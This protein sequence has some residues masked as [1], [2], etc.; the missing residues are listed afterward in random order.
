M[1]QTEMED[2]ESGVIVK[3]VKEAGAEGLVVRGG[4]KEGIFVKEV[5][6][7]SPAS[8]QLGVKEGDQILSATVYFDDVSYED[9]LQIL[10]HAQACKMELC[11][12]RKTPSTQS[13]LER[14]TD[15]HLEMISGEEGAS[16]VERGRRKTQRRHEARISWPKFPSFSR[17]RKAYFKRSHSTS[18]AEEEKLQMSPTTSDTESP[19]K[20]QEDAK[21]KT[22]RQKVK[23]SKGKMSLRSKSADQNENLAVEAALGF[24][25]K[26]E[27]LEETSD[28]QS[29]EPQERML[30]E[31]PQT[32]LLDEPGRKETARIRNECTFPSV[33][34]TEAEIGQHKSELI[35]LDKTLKTTD[36]TKS[37]ADQKHQ[38]AKHSPDGKK[39]KKKERSELKVNIQGKEKEEWSPDCLLTSLQPLVAHSSPKVSKTPD[40]ED[41]A[42]DLSIVLDS[43][44]SP[45]VISHAEVK[46]HQ[47]AIDITTQRINISQS[48]LVD[49]KSA[50]EKLSSQ[51]MAK[52]EN[53]D[54]N[55]TKADISFGMPDV[56]TSQK[57]QKTASG[58]QRK[59]RSILI[60][61]LERYGIR[62]RSSTTDRDLTKTHFVV[63]TTKVDT[64]PLKTIVPSSGGLFQNISDMNSSKSSS[65]ASFLSEKPQE[66]VSD[67]KGS[68]YSKALDVG[69]K[70]SS[71][72]I[73][74]SDLSAETNTDDFKGKFD[75]SIS[76]KF[77]VP[78]MDL[79]DFSVHEPIAKT[80]TDITHVERKEPKVKIKVPNTDQQ[81]LAEK[82]EKKIHLPKREDI[83][84]PGMEAT[85]SKGILPL[86]ALKMTVD[87]HMQKAGVDDVKG[88]SPKTDLSTVK[89]PKIDLPDLDTHQHI[90]KKDITA[91]KV[92]LKDAADI[93]KPKT[94]EMITKQQD[95]SA[96]TPQTVPNTAS[97]YDMGD[98]TEGK[99]KAFEMPK[100]TE[101][102][103]IAELTKRSA[104]TFKLPKPKFPDADSHEPI[105]MTKLES[106][107]VNAEI[108]GPKGEV[109]IQ[110]E[111]E[112]EKI[113]IEQ[114]KVNRPE[115]RMKLPN[116][117]DFEIPGREAKIASTDSIGSLAI[118][119][120]QTGEVIVPAT[121]NTEMQK[122]Q[123]DISANAI[124]DTDFKISVSAMKLPKVE[125]SG[126]DR[127]QQI[128]KT[129]VN[130]GKKADLKN[131]I[132]NT[133][134]Q[135]KELVAQVK[136]GKFKV[137]Q[138][139]YDDISIP[140]LKS[141]IKVQ[142]PGNEV[143]PDITTTKSVEAKTPEA[144]A[145]QT[146]S[147]AQDVTVKMERTDLKY[148]V[149]ESSFVISKPELKLP[150]VSDTE[151]KISDVSDNAEPSKHQM[152]ISRKTV[153][154]KKD[155]AES[156]GLKKDMDSE[157]KGD[158]FE[159]LSKV[160]TEMQEVGAKPDVKGPKL[161][162]DF[163]LPSVN[164]SL[165]KPDAGI[166]VPTVSVDGSSADVEL[167]GTQFK[168]S[169]QT[170]SLDIQGSSVDI[171]GPGVDVDMQGKGA[172]LQGQ[173][174]KFKMAKFGI[175]MPKVKGPEVD[176]SISK[177]GVDISLPK[178]QATAQLPSV[179]VEVPSAE[180]QAELPE[181]DIKDIDVKLKKPKVSFPKFGFSKDGKAPEVDVS[182]SKGEV[183]V[184]EG[185][186]EIKSPEIDGKADAEVGGSP[187]KFKLPHFKLPKFGAS[188][189]K[190]KA[191]LTDVQVDVKVPEIEAP[192]GKVG[193]EV[194]APGID[195]DRPDVELDKTTAEVTMPEINISLPKITRPEI[196]FKTPKA[197]M[198]VAVS[199]PAAE[200]KG[201]SIEGK[202][203]IP[204][205]EAGGKAKFHMPS[206]KMPSL[207]F[208]KPDVKGPKLS[209]DFSLPSVNVS[210]TKPDAGIAVPTVSVDGSS[211]DV[212][213]PGTQFKVSGQ[214]PSLDIQGSSVDIEGPG[215]DVDMQGKGADLQG[216]GSKFK[217]AKFGISMPK[218]KGPEVDISIS[219]PGVDISLPKAQAT[220]QLPSVD[221]EVPSAE[222]QAELPEADIKDIDVKLKKPKVSFP[223][224]G[225]SKDGKAPE[226]D[227]SLSK[228]E[229]PVPEGSVEI[230]SPEI[231]GKADAEVGGSP[232]KFKL[233]HFKLPK[234]GASAP[235]GKA[236]LTDV[237]VDVKV[238]EIEAP[239]GKVGMEVKAP[240]ID[241][242]RPDVELDK[243]TA[244]VTMPEINISLPKI[245][246]P[247]IEFKTPKAEM[248][249]AVSKPAAEMKGPSI[250][251]KTE[252]P[253]IEAGG[254]AKFHMPSI[255]MPSLGFS[256]PDV[257]GPKLSGDFSLPSVNVSL[258]KPDAGIAVPTV[259]VDGSSA[260]VEL[261][262]TQFKVSGQTPSLD[263]QGSSVDIEGPG[264]DVDMQGKGADLQG[265]GSKFKMAK[266]G[267]SMPK[268]KGPEVDISISKPGVDISLPKAQATA[269]LPSVDV[270]VPSAEGQAE[271][272]E[273]DIKDIDV[274]LKKP[275]VSFP[276][277][278]FSKDGKAPEVDVSL[279]KGEVPVPEGSVEIK[280]PEIDGKADAE[281]GGSPSKFKLP[282]FKLPKFGASAPK[283][284]AEL[285]DVQVDVKV[286][287]IEAPSGKV[288]MEVKAPGIDIDR[289]D[290]ELDKTTAEV[291]M[292]EIN[293]SLPKIT[294]P[295]IEFKTPKAEMDVAVSKPAAEMKG[296]SI[297][298]KTE[299]PDI[300]AGG[301]AKFHMPSIKMPSLGFSKPD[302]K[303]PK[304]SGDFS[305]PSV[306]VSLTKPDAGIAVPTVSVD[307]SSADVELPGTQ[308]KVSGQTPS[309]DIQGSSVDIEGP[310]V[311]VDMQ[312][313]G[314]DLQGQGSKF[315]MAK[316]GISMPKVKGPEVDISISKPGVDISLP[317]A[318]ATA[319]LPSVDVE[320]PSAEGQAELP[321]A[322]I[323]DID[324]KLKKPKVSFPKFGFSK[325]GKAPEV[326]VSLSKGEVPVPEGSVEIKSP[327]I[328]GKADAEVGGSPSKFKLPHFKLP[329]FG[330]SAPKGKAELTDVQ[331]DVKVPEIEAP[332]GK[333]GME[334]KAPGIDIDRPD[335]E[336]D[337][338]TAEVTMPEINISLPKITRPE[339]E[340]KTPKAEMDVAVSKP[341]AEM[342]G[343]SI[344]GKTEIP[345]IEAGGKAKFHM[346][347][348]KM[349]SLG[350]SKPDV[351]GPKLS[352]DFSLPSVNVS[353]TKP[354]AGIAVPTVS[355]DGSSA[356]V[357]LPGTQFKVSGQTPSL[358]IQGSSV[359]IEGPGV[360][361]DMQ[362]KGADLQGQ[363]SKFKMAKFGISMPKVKGPEVDISISKPGVDIS[364]PKAQATAQLPSV[365]VE[366]PSAE[367][368]A[369]LPEADIKDID[370]KLKKPKV[371][372]PKFGFSKDGKAPEVDV[373]LSKGEVP[374]PEGSV[375]IKSPEIDGKADAEVGGSPSKFKLPH[376]KLPK[377]GASAPKGKAELTDV[378]V[379]VKVPEIEAPSGKVGMEVKAP[380]IDIDRP[381]VELDKTTAEVTMPEIN[382]SLPKI[383]RP[384][385]EFKTPKAEMD[386]AV[387]K[388]A[389]EMKGP[390]IEGKTEIPDI[391]AGGKAKFHMP[392]IKMPSLGF[393]KPDVKGP[394]LSGDFSL[395]SVNVSLTKPDAGIAVPTVSVD[396]SS[397]DVELP[398]TQF[399]VSGQTP[400]LD[401]QG[402][403]VDIEGPGVDVD[404]QGKGADLQG[405]GSKFKM[406]KF[407]ISMPKVKGPEVDISIS[408]PGVDISLPKAQATAQLPSVDVEVPSA[409]G[410]AELPEADIKDIDVKL[411]KPKVSFPKFG[412]SKDGKAPEV[413]VSLSK[414]EVPVPEGSVEI[415]SPEIDGKAD[416][417]VGGSPSKFKLP[418]FKL[419]K[420]GASAPK[421]KAELTDVQ[422]DVKVP[423][424]EAPSGK[425][426]MEVKAPGIDIDRPDVELDKTTAEVTM[427]E[428]NISLP[429][430]TRPEIEFKTPKAEMDVAVSKPAAEMKGPSIE[431][432]TEIPD[433]EAGGKAKFHM[434][435]IKMPSLGFS[436]PDVKGPKL[437]GDFSLPSVNVSLT[438][439]DAGIA[440]PTVSVDGSSADVELPGT[441]FKVSGQTPSL[442][443]QGSSVD[444][445]GPGVDVDMQGKGADLQGQ[446]S[447]FKMAK[448]GISMPKVKG[449][450]V[451]ISISKPGVDI[452]LPKAQATAQL[453]S[454][455]VEVPSAEGQAELPEADIKDIDVKLK[456]PK[457]SFPK[458]GFS[459]DGKAPEVDVSL[460]K[461]E[462]PVPEGSVEIKS[463]EID[464][465]AD[466]EVGGSPSKFKLPHFKLPKFGASAPKGKAELTDVQVDVKVPEIEAPSGKVGME[467]KAPG[468]DIDRPD[469][470]LDKTTAE[471][472]MP[473]INISL[474]KITRPEIEFKTPKAEMD[475]A[476]SKPAAEM[477][478]PS[479]EGKTEIPDI[480]A[481]GKA[482]FHMPSIKMPSLG[483]SKPDVKGPK[484]SGDFSLPS[485]NVSLTKPDAGIAVPTV[486]VDGSSADV[487]LPGTQFKVSGQ[488]PSLD[489][490]GSSVDIEGPGVD[491]DMQGKGAD[492]QGQGSK[493]KMAKFGIS[494]P[495]VKGPEVDISISKPG[496]DISL[497][498]A[499][500]TA[501][502]PS[503]DVEVP[504]AEG[505][506]E[507]PE[508]DI[509]DIDVKLKK[510]KVSFPKFGFSKD[511]KAPEVDVSLS[512]GEVPVPEG[513]VEIKSPEI[514]GKADA[515]VGGSPSKFKLPHF[516]LPKFGASAPKGKAE[517]TDVQVDVK[518]PEIEAPSGKVGMEVKAPGIDIDRPDVELDKTTAEVTMPEIN[519]SLPKITRPEIEFKT[520]KAEMDVAVS[521]PAAEMKGPSIEGK[522]EIPDIE[523]GG[524]AKFHM[525]SI[526]M[527]SLGFSKPDVKGP[528]LSG[529]FS[530]P[531]VNVS[532]TKPDAG[533]AVPTVSV[534]GSSA[535]VELPGTQ[536]KVSGQT[537]SLD[538][539][540]SSVDIEGP[541][542]DVDMQGKGADLQGQGSKFKMAKFG[543]SM[544]K[545]KGPEVDISIS[546]PGVDISLPKAQA[547]AQ[548]PSVDVEVPSAEGQAEL[549][550]ADIKDIDVKL[551]KPKVSF[552]KFG[553]SKDGKAPEVDVSLSK[554]EVPVPEGS[555]EIKS[556]E[557]DGKADAE[558]GGSPS[559]FK[560]PHFKLPKFG[561][562]APKGKAELTDVQVDVKVPEIEAPS[563]KVGMEVKAPGID[564]DRPDV[565][566][567]K[568]TAE[569]TMPEINISLPKITR[570]EIEFK[571]PKAE[572]DVAV[573]KPAAEMK[574]PSIEGK[575]EIPDIEAGGKAKFHMP[576]IKMPSLGFSKPDVKGP[577]LSGDFS[578]PS[579]NV[580]LTK[581]DAGIAVP[582]VSVD[583][584][585]ADVE[586][587]G[588]QF[589]VSGQTPSLD[590]Q[591][592]SVDIE[593]PGVDVDMQGKGADL[594]GQG[595]KFK[596]AKFGISM[597]KVKGP[598]VDI[599]ISKPGVDISLPKAQ[600]TAQLPSVDVE[601]PSAEGQA[602]LPE[603]DIK[604]IDVKLKKPKV[605]FP[606]FGFS[607][608]GK[609]PEVDVSLSKGEVP[610]PEGSV[611]IK[612]PEIDGKADAEVGG[613]PSKF[614]LPHFK[615]PKFGASAPKGKAELT[616]VQ[617]D[618]K[619][620]EIEAPSGKV[621][622]EVKAPGI[623]IDRPDVE[624]DKTTAEVT[625]PEINISL[626]KITRPEIEFK[627][628][629]AEMDVAVSKP[630]AEMKGPSIEGKTE[631]PDIEAGGKA[632]FHMPS[633]K[634]PSLGFSKPDVKGPK[635]SGDFSLPSVN[636]SLT[637]PDAGI[638]VPTVSV[639][640][641]S[642][643]VELPGTQFKVS[644]QTPSLDIQ[645][646][647]VDIEGPGVD[648]D[649]QGKG[650]D[651]QGQGSKF[652]MAK[653]GI[654]MPKVKG[655]E[656]DI[657]ISKPGVDISLPKAQATAQLPSVDV[658]V[659]SAE[660]QAELPE[661]DIK[662]IDVK[663][664]KPKV[665]FPKF[666]FSKDGKAPEVDVSLSKGEV[667]VPE[668]SVEIKSPEI[669]G[670]AD[671][672]V[673]GSPSKFK[674]PH[675]KLPKFGA[676]APKGKAELT[677][678][679]VDVKVPEIEAPSG[680]V[681]MEVK[682]PGI[683]IDRPDVELDKT[684]AE[685]T[686]PEI[687][688]SLPKI[689]RP[690]IEFKT[691]KAEMDVAVSKPAA[692]MKGPSI[693]GK[694]EI[695][696]IEAGGKAKFHMPSIKMPSLGF[697]KPD[698]KGP[699]LSGDFS[700]PS[701]NV[702]L[703][704]PD[705]GI[706]V[707]TVSVDGSSA[708]VELPGTQ[709][710][711]S[712]QT[713][714]LDIQGSSVDIEG[715]GVDV[716]MQGKGA[717]LQGQGSKFKMAKFGISMPKVKG[718][719][720]DISI[721]KPGVDISLPKAQATAQL[722]SVDVEV[723]SAEGQAE[724]PEA[725][726]KDIDVKL[727]K[728]KVSFPKFGFSKD[729]KAPE[730]DVSLS[731]GEV[732]VPE[733][734]VEI[735][736]PEIDGKADAEVGGS[737]SKFK[738]PHF[739]LPKFGA[740][741][742]KGK[743]ELT[744]VQVDVKVPEIEAPSGK[745]GMEVK[746]PGID[747]D[748][749][750]VELDKTTAEVTM[751]EINIS[752]PKIT[753]PE[754]EF[755]TP[756]AE[757]DVA[758]SKPAAEMK[759]PSTE[760][761]LRG[762]DVKVDADTGG[763][764][765]KF[766]LP[767][768]T[769]PKFGI[770]GPKMTVE[771][772]DLNSDNKV[773]EAHISST[774][775]G[776]IAE[777]S[778]VENV[779]INLELDKETAKSE[780]EF[781]GPSIDGKTE[782]TGK[783]IYAKGKKPRISFPKFG[784][785]KPDIKSS[786]VNVS[787]PIGDSSLAEGNIE[788][789][790]SETD[791]IAT[792]IEPK[793]EADV[794]SSP[795]KYKLPVIKMPKFGF[796]SAKEKSTDQDTGTMQTDPG[797]P[798]IPLEGT[799][800]KL[801]KQIDS[802]HD[803]KEETSGLSLSFPEI[804]SQDI[805]STRLEKGKHP[806]DQ[807]STVLEGGEHHA[808][809][810]VLD[811]PKVDKGR[812]H[813]K[814][815]EPEKSS[816][817]N[818][819]SFGDVFRGFELEFHVPKLD[820]DEKTLTSPK[821]EIGPSAIEEQDIHGKSVGKDLGHQPKF[822]TLTEGTAEAS[823]FTKEAEVKEMSKFKFWFPKISFAE[824]TEKSKSMTSNVV[825]EKK[826]MLTHPQEKKETEDNKEPEANTEKGS[827][828]KFSKFGTTSPSKTIKESEKVI[829]LPKENLDK[830]NEGEV[831]EEDFSLTSSV[832]SS[833]AFA[834]I[835]STITSEQ[836][837]PS[838]ASPTK[839]M[840]KY[841]E[842]AVIIGVGE[843]KVPGDVITS[844][845]RTELI[846][847]EPK[848]PEKFE[849]DTIP[850]AEGETSLLQHTLREKTGDTHDITPDIQKVP[851]TEQVTIVTKLET[852]SVQDESLKKVVKMAT[853]P[854]TVEAPTESLSKTPGE[855]IM[856][857]KCVVKEKS[858]DEKG[859]VV[860]TQK[861]THVVRG[862][863]G[864]PAVDDAASAIK[865]LKDTMHSEKLRFFEGDETL[866][867]TVSTHG[868]ETQMFEPS[869]ENK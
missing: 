766:K 790:V 376:F 736:S 355:V 167:P 829:S 5:K 324:V 684:T 201:P 308:F 749:P 492:L 24:V 735:K 445:E 389:A 528:K 813:M 843:V 17:G 421:G 432:K 433:I 720:V 752:L 722:P 98:K 777:A 89:L 386:V 67:Y 863:L 657:S 334:V 281:V 706:A 260:D 285:T 666:G 289:P 855:H 229:V 317:K 20:T 228:G 786:D 290:V 242:D 9:A 42:P 862:D 640:G 448:F 531:S 554:G 283:G 127:D 710:K 128:T 181:A 614:K 112:G 753:R 681:G 783:E 562:S 765:R 621:G 712:G 294:R 287:E 485:V 761:N 724:L 845:A 33:S 88:V 132:S 809:G 99:I 763:S 550:E 35:S 68:G 219:K 452:S 14:S 256:K 594:Q 483:F 161:S 570:P 486:S 686:M 382:I 21:D 330:A 823:S 622:M 336:L 559:K 520:P 826:D 861:V 734:S 676:S 266:F 639:D 118:K 374:V 529:D 280:S 787:L 750:D 165:T 225:F 551:K 143:R 517:L 810:I 340:F 205:I 345:D 576:S 113:R 804:K 865:K 162:G 465:K 745:V 758:V 544:P 604:D 516:K 756:K 866:R 169:G 578:L 392:S 245:T 379:D 459:K 419:P 608:D 209:G 558:V 741:A 717:D 793:V 796:S 470:E 313:K 202:T 613:S 509:K 23:V 580:S 30:T 801:D 415:K 532:L 171:E 293:I 101:N 404:M 428:I 104:P 214:T 817:F 830:N 731:K 179:D 278:G 478:G 185:S 498:K 836:V 460:S 851:D 707:P 439:P 152:T 210:L 124:K 615:L 234:F 233:P 677:D 495:K 743:A 212:E 598:E 197:E 319:Q 630:A 393:S 631:I 565:E 218:V 315:K 265:Q 410:Q 145:K 867:V 660:G 679:Q 583:G 65:A 854:W 526:K 73:D 585:S 852:R 572:M 618:V 496:V 377:F 773:S 593:G 29:P 646:S 302:V 387:S 617:V 240:G 114:L 475:V 797:S 693:E 172:D 413:D 328:D 344:E 8:K 494:M 385:I 762:I 425:V 284:K 699:K 69:I 39:R 314:A 832:R 195:I 764:S 150:E 420:F 343:P 3:A 186:V 43:T 18:E 760:E 396:G 427:P 133:D 22:K 719:E 368:Q 82:I 668:G 166:A 221:V 123:A 75:T 362:G 12:K 121:G 521:K 771:S 76:P 417:E 656:V 651:L 468:I 833:D 175:S 534:D 812:I 307:G 587:P 641:S 586:L 323:K 698:V 781:K 663:L 555:V 275:K 543:I 834:D 274:K 163:S 1:S 606:K 815:E 675:F 149:K 252:I 105:L 110:K 464:G 383:T 431:G 545:V 333:V 443:I 211:A 95:V 148:T 390:S 262:G 187:S 173:G 740:S 373:S 726:I 434:P 567:D 746:A 582:T 556:P 412:F 446:G 430:I 292:P 442:D 236:E 357:E 350:F 2:I 405:Q 821:E 28:L 619:V 610:V 347:S 435:S 811:A 235:K 733:G 484:L 203:E 325:D 31:T 822:S 671:A 402:S 301:K 49:Q 791:M 560:L 147:K 789:K 692:E 199:K 620:P 311:D 456:K 769:F 156:E 800:L 182:L 276:K 346:P 447:K 573:S 471:V 57:Y 522:T 142:K 255:K 658:E 299:I 322:D 702:S 747:I 767:T 309:L 474:P 856:V 41:R 626:P 503:V 819:P 647:S 477:K 592:S 540:G 635:L 226:V 751:P 388:P 106:S 816:R 34:G 190:G 327:E 784:F 349:P 512:K 799:T 337:K 742:P 574:G 418:H 808:S 303:G 71:L 510:P 258:T 837:G 339:I 391:E 94:P 444:I 436:K 869:T 248:D 19:I 253:D 230:K 48:T 794:G 119:H 678:V 286:P 697:S 827:W 159:K 616:D 524:K 835:S 53:V 725:D 394:K 61:D 367:G 597:P 627:T 331:V 312:G 198:D 136:K 601:V 247:E 591:G 126:P 300:E 305:L 548:L 575:T 130:A 607:K 364:L 768:F 10:E 37:L 472:T 263:I 409:E 329:K 134:V 501:Q 584:S 511:G 748:R 66:K 716:D 422:V 568:T 518:V 798:G 25:E 463:P 638:A 360:D 241:I 120:P 310:G 15:T 108:L 270:E 306:N 423:E 645:G 224:F 13:T 450:E 426:G 282:H 609:A 488:T 122:L 841:S 672:E 694:T 381:D 160:K 27:T 40:T 665:S 243:T 408:K 605:S 599:S 705:A 416:A 546:K 757:M 56:S 667:P 365:D 51:I 600:A 542:V 91:E 455:D 860:I 596:M 399:K 183:P 714:S 86:S 637:K 356:D 178:A 842:P 792:E 87:I 194:K 277:F 249:V 848:L 131:E 351:K 36:I 807:P 839:V 206:I 137:P 680:K 704:K 366:V 533:I 424:I 687:N 473:E 332:S 237:Q 549:P 267:I 254:K 154:I 625:M 380:G 449:P 772:K 467:V 138:M 129:D 579:V 164:V 264:V 83:E 401:I 153:D 177:P 536:F 291:T 683:D 395:P 659:P 216:Q 636:V 320:V 552:P 788:I 80:E 215:V 109:N 184:P 451:D 115:I 589:K 341:A 296:P 624:L 372:F 251:G 461:G 611:E 217:M 700:L 653:F 868:I 84:I 52:K 728:P 338:T 466:A 642:A 776:M 602:E 103:S 696:D 780:V 273:A 207:G 370:V 77:K 541:G 269:Q 440:V 530:L 499:Q 795:R 500:A 497:P 458:F 44:V 864:E 649:M 246:R 711:V 481:G 571:T 840:V 81:I 785:S 688:I 577:K 26:K 557:I 342:K 690:E 489:I 729:G 200:M 738:L 352:G 847:L 661:A 674:L 739:K 482:K 523:A 507:L 590:I 462:V 335:V 55:K 208:S 650:A 775:E 62:S 828:F 288:G 519:I 102:Y 588:T 135:D 232:S 213:L 566:L 151:M 220:A 261:P 744:D 553:F 664:K 64:S 361:V 732:P 398:G 353:L 824:S 107:E 846:C 348:I 407:G 70:D 491:V 527:P 441:Q 673:G 158:L 141:E 321:E 192:S 695:P 634:M 326:D 250:E 831:A 547:T 508:A 146:Q 820:E 538:I 479:I 581:P 90:T 358:D 168:V 189:P 271:L 629:K 853:V 378:Q 188:A 259:S 92:K 239:S 802:S 316:F 79:K 414:G 737:P 730:V 669:D 375:E 32:L 505:Q 279:S 513:S 231:D 453:P 97:S 561:A 838:E 78:K 384:E 603:A 514:D 644:G 139:P 116:R 691:P 457:V 46:E 755:K 437:S 723:P 774:G 38:S 718:P 595:S 652:K 770:T 759:G 16:P 196:E 682:A 438:K 655:P 155:K 403:S 411:K 803:S 569:V 117:E 703:T 633:I 818:L 721:S 157:N 708:D 535:D 354:D 844:T 806:V 295:E 628:P 648:V 111:R 11:L 490:Q 480:E 487:E 257:K 502:L 244:E 814:V 469:V 493:F 713:P 805:I 45:R 60:S 371:S 204:D 85:E 58:K 72:N 74:D 238:P 222:G 779:R 859:T 369:E 670:K 563:G 93:P 727:K 525:P 623:D 537:P 298:G 193:M 850:I 6:P 144:Q 50:G 170:P 406:A 858:G 227:V 701:V 363:G 654:S 782:I 778:E 359:D 191:E 47:M 304:L 715:P 506:A 709:F 632:K 504:S 140:T 63:P 643:D 100:Q 125:F 476:V 176:I 297:E 272:P 174:S 223:K 59:E 564:I 397:A 268:V 857:E 612:S 454:V 180:G 318:Q 4:G 849:T 429:K 96:I 754:I 662:D 689:T 7:E 685:V 400:S 539:Q 54:A 515:E 825:T